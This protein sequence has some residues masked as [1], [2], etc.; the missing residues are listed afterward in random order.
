MSPTALAAP[1]INIFCVILIGFMIGW[2]YTLGLFLAA[3]I[4][5]VVMHG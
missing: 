4:N 3:I 1:F 2:W 5:L